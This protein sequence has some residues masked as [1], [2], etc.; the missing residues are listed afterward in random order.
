MNK[1]LSLNINI[2]DRCWE[3]RCYIAPE[4]IYFECRQSLPHY[5]LYLE[6]IAKEALKTP[7]TYFA[8]QHIDEE[9]LKRYELELQ[10]ARKAAQ[11]MKIYLTNLQKT[12]L[13]VKQGTEVIARD[14]YNM[15]TNQLEE[16][17]NLVDDERDRS[18]RATNSGKETGRLGRGRARGGSRTAA[19]STSTAQEAPPQPIQTNT[20]SISQPNQSKTNHNRNRGGRIGNRGRCTIR[21]SRTADANAHTTSC[22][23]NDTH[24]FIRELQ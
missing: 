22:A 18:R 17:Q 1:L 2:V 10:N 13:A 7:W 11:A 19:C 3:D 20:E 23:G 6:I 16:L 12:G 15:T 5:K 14:G 8:T 9:T 24:I 4:K 21:E